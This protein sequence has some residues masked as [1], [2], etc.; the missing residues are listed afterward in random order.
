MRSIPS[1]LVAFIAVCVAVVVCSI[2]GC[3]YMIGG[4][5]NTDIATV[6][7]P[8]FTS[9]SF[10]RGLE[11]QLTEAVLREIKS[12]TPYRIAKAPF[13]DTRLTG[14]IV[15]LT[16]RP[17]TMTPGDEPRE[18]QLSYAVEVTWTD[19]RSNRGI[20]HQEIEIPP[21]LVHLVADAEFAPEVGASLATG[22]QEALDRLARRI[23]EMMEAPW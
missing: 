12:R 6:E 22:N 9:Q 17:L 19:L 5:Y 15:E 13:A 14:N 16:K 1:I 11:F 23:V 21:D 20:M 18:L 2:A 4:G 8:M 7:V 10:R 3:G